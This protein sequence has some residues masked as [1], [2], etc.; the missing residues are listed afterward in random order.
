MKRLLACV[1]LLLPV[2][3]QAEPIVVG[4][5]SFDIPAPE[6]YALVTPE[7]TAVQEALA[8][9]VA[10]QYTGFA[11]FI[12][13]EG[14]ADALAGEVPS[15]RRR[16]SVQTLKGFDDRPMSNMEFW[17]FKFAFGAASS[18]ER[19]KARKPQNG[20]EGEDFQ[21]LKSHDESRDSVA[22]STVYHYMDEEESGAKT[23]HGVT[24]TVMMIHLKDKLL[25][26]TAHGGQDDLEWTRAAIKSWGQVVRERNPTDAAAMVR[27]RMPF[28]LPSLDWGNIL[29]IALAAVGVW[30]L[31]ALGVW[32][33]V[34]PR[35]PASGG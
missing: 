25:M 30:L 7:M 27:Q 29:P 6:G 23:R 4:G 22:Y 26:L 33:L 15:L 9:S 31:L 34:R 5:T 1:L 32:W 8:P 13:A 24:S 18:G 21:M 10:E 3:A 12:P 11:W 2:L 14:V 35:K 28:P 19:D 20:E 17:T 16:F